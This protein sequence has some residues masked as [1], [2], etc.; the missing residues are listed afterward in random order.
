MTKENIEREGD[1]LGDK[2][3]SLEEEKKS[4]SE[5]LETATTHIQ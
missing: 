3:K 5:S 1:Q 4:L 2:V